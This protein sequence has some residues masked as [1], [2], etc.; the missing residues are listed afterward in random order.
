M[1]NIYIYINKKNSHILL[2]YIKNNF[3]DK[4]YYPNE[5]VIVITVFTETVKTR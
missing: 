4:L 2:A 5:D 1:R 3:T